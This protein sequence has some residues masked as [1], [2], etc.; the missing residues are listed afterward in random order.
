MVY[1]KA[2]HNI[3]GQKVATMLKKK[4]IQHSIIL[5]QILVIF[6]F[7][8]ILKLIDFDNEDT[9]SVYIF[10]HSK[11]GKLSVKN[12]KELAKIH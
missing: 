2:F 12:I 8:C 11:E 5:I 3:H 7:V 9:K 10:L 4:P 1:E 6:F